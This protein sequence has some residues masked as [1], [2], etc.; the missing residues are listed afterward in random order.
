MPADP[1]AAAATRQVYAGFVEALESDL[2]APILG[3]LF[4]QVRGSGASESLPLAQDEEVLRMLRRVGL[5]EPEAPSEEIARRVAQY[6]QSLAT[7]A[8]RTAAQVSVVLRLYASG[9]YGLVPHPICGTAPRCGACGIRKVCAHHNAP[10]A[11][12]P[13]APLGK[14]VRRE[15]AEALD[16]AE[17]LAL[18][19]GGDRAGEAHL[20]TGRTL[21][22]RYGTLR[23]LAAAP[24]AELADLRDVAAS[25]AVRLAAAA[26]LF[27]RLQ[28]ERRPANPVMR[29]GRDFYDLYQPRLRDLRKEVFLTVLLDQK[30]RVLKEIRVS[31]GTLTASLVHPR[32]A[33][34]PAIRESAAAVAF[35]HNHPSGD[36][37]PS[38]EDKAITARLCDAGR[39]VGIRVLDHVIIGEDSY[40]SLLDEGLIPASGNA[41]N[42]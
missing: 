20:E 6:V 1:T 2:T 35:V 32:E 3:D 5:I 22:A 7:A 21:L 11:D 23:A 36:S 18:L 12:G 40:T 4:D 26:G 10:R 24:V 31:E 17:L 27:A 15:G 39:I 29:S 42:P 34:A 19:L 25:A 28:A 8:E 16:E 33:F 41:G 9:F 14:R 37:R 13:R 30:H 38:P